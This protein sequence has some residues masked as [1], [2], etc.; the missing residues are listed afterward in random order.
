MGEVFTKEFRSELESSQEL[1]IR[2]QKCYK[3]WET[4]GILNNNLENT[5]KEVKKHVKEHNKK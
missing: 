1:Y 4:F 5:L 3:E 2:C